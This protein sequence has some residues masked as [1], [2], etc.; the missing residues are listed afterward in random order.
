MSCGSGG[1]N[2]F[3]EDYAAGKEAVKNFLDANNDGSINIQ[4]LKTKKAMFWLTAGSVFISM[5][6]LL[7]MFARKG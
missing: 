2:Q 7:L 6:T 4:D 5:V 3:S 1:N